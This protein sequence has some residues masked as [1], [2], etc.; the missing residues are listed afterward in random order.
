MGIRKRFL[1]KIR[2][3]RKTHVFAG[4]SELA[5]S[6]TT[7]ALVWLNILVQFLFPM[8]LSFSPVLASTGEQHF[9]IKNKFSSDIPTQ[10]YV[11]TEGENV[12]SVTRKFNISREALR[13]LNQFRVFS[14]GFDNITAGDELDVPV[15]A[16]TDEQQ[17]MAATRNETDSASRKLAGYASQAGSFFANGPDGDSAAAM[18]RGMATS[19]ATEEIQNWLNRFG[20]ARVRLSANEDFS[21]DDSELDL[22]IPL[23]DRG[24]NMAFTQGSV[25]R[26]D[27]RTQANLGFGMRH[28]AD[29]YMFG[30]NVFGDYDIS[31]QHARLGAGLEYWRDYLKVGVNGYK[32]LTG[33]KD[34]PDLDDYEERPADGWDVR[35]QGWL[36]AYPQLGGKLVYEQYY[37]DEVGLFG[38][39]DLQ[40][41]PHAV[42]AGVTYTPFPL[43]T[44]S[45][46][47]RQGQSGEKDTQVALD[48]NYQ[49][50]VPWRKQLDSG[51]VADMRTLSGSRYDLVERNNNIVLQYRKK[52]LI[53][54][55]TAKLVTGHAGEKKSLGVSVTSKYGVER[56]DWSAPELLAAGGVIGKK[57]N[58]WGV[59]LPAWKSGKNA[60]NTYSV[61]GIAVDTKGNRS[62]KS[63][64]QVTVFK[65]ALSAKNST[66][67]PQKSTLPADGKSKQTLTLLVRDDANKAVDI[68]TSEITL[69]TSPVK[70]AHLSELAEKGTGTYELTVTAGKDAEVINVTPKIAGVSLPTATIVINSL[71]PDAHHSSFTASPDH[72]P[73]DNTT[74]SVLTFRAGD[75]QGKQITGI[76]D[77][78][79]FVAGD[80]KTRKKASAE[81]LSV[82]E[83]TESDAGIYTATVKGSKAMNTTF[84]P[85]FDNARVGELKAPLTLTATA[86]AELQSAISVDKPTYAAGDTIQVTVSLK[87]ASGNPVAG[88]AGEL[89]DSTV[90]VPN[91]ALTGK[92]TD[93]NNGT[94]SAAYKAETAGSNLK[95]T[96]KL[97]AWSKAVES[98]AYDITATAPDQAQSAITVDKP[99]YKAGDAISVTVTLKDKAGNI[100]AGA[101]HALTDTTVHVQ[102][103]RPAGQWTDNGDGTYAAAYTALTAGTGLK[104]TLQ[105]EGWS[106]ADESDAYVITAGDAVA[107]QSAIAV[108]KPAYAAGDT[109]AVTVTLK[110]T[111]SNGVTGK[112]DV[113]TDSTVK[114]PNASLTGQW[115]D[116]KNGTYSAAYK[117][118]TAGSNLK[119]T[120]KLSGWN[121]TVESDAYGITATAPDQAKS[122][123]TVDKPAYKAGDAI[124]VTVTLKDKAGNIVAGAAD[125]LTDTTVHVQNAR[126]AGQWTDNGDG[127]YAS[128]Y[129]ALTAGTGLK[130]TL[131]LEGWSQADESDAYVITAGDAVAKQSAIA[132]DKPAYA[133]GETI[134]VTVTLKDT[135]SNG[136]TGKA[137]ALTDSTVKVPNASQAGQWTD[138]GDGTYSAAYTAKTVGTDLKATLQ[139]EGWSQADESD[140]YGI[141]ATAPDQAQSAITVDKS[142]YK[143]GDA[144]SVTVTLKDKAG[145]VVTGAA[146]ALTDTTVKVQ[147]ARPAGQWTDNG[148]GTY[149]AAYTALTAGTGL[150]AT[151]Q[152]E[153]WSKADESAV[154]D[155]V[156]GDAVAGQSAIAVDKPAYAAGDTIAVTVTL[157][158]TGSNAVTGKADALTDSTVKVPNASLTGQ[159]TDNGDGTYSAAYTANTVGTDLK[160]TL[161]LEGWSQAD[162]SDAYVITAGDAVAEQSAIAVDK[163]AYTAGEAISVTV[164]LKD[165]AGNIVAG[166]ADALSDTTVKVQN[167]TLTGKWTDNGDGTYSA[168]YTAK[169][170]GTDLKATLQLEGWS[171]ADE[172]DAY[173]ITAGDAVAEQSA[174]AVDKPAYAAGDTIA[175]TV[176]L[177]DTG[178]NAVTGKADALTDSTVKVPNASQAGQWTDNGDGTYS[179][180]Y[181]AKTV[182]TDLKAT[183]QLEGW[184]KADE[185]DAYGI[186]ATAPDQ[187][188]SSIAVDKPAYK[189]GDAISVTV[190]LKDKAGNVVTGAADALTDA[191]VKVQNA[192]PAGQWTDNGDGTY[193]ATYTARTAGTGLK[194]TLQLEDW[195]QADESDAYDIVA[196]DAVAGE[197]AIAVDKPAYAAG[198][199]I[200]VTVTLKDTGS[201]AVTGKADALTDSTVK[202]PNAGL[203]GQWTDNGDGTYSAAYTANTVGTD[204]KATLQLEGWSQADESDV[205]T[206]T[207][208]EAAA[209]QSTITVAKSSY[210]AGQDVKVIV[211]LK[212]ESGNAVSGAVDSLNDN[213][214]TVPGTSGLTGDWTESREGQYE[215]T[216]QAHTVGTGLTATL[217]L[218]DWSDTVESKSSYEIIADRPDFDNSE[219]TVDKDTYEVGEEIHAKAIIKDHYGNKAELDGITSTSCSSCDSDI[220]GSDAGNWI[221]WTKASDGAYTATVKAA[222]PG[223]DYEAVIYSADTYISPESAELHSNKYAV[224]AGSP[225]AEQSAIKVDK[226]SYTSGETIK[227]TVSLKDASGNAVVGQTDALT[228]DTVKVSGAATFT[229][230]WSDSGDGTY[231]AE[232]TA[233]TAGTGLKATLQL[234]GW[235]KANESGVYDITAGDAV[236]EASA[237]KV[238]KKAYKTGETIDVTVTL[239]DAGNNAVAGAAQ[240]LTDKSVK[241]EGAAAFTGTWT[242]NGDG[243]YSAAYTAQ[244]PGTD[245]KATL[246]LEGW[247]KAD[248]SDVYAITAGAAAAAQ[249]TI[250]VAES[251]Y[252]AG[253]DVK[254]IVHLKDESGNAVSGAVDSLNDNTVTVPGTSGLT[255][256]WTESGNGTYEAT[257]QAH[258]VGTNLTATL[259]LK[260]WSDTVESE[261]S[262]EIIADRPD[263][264]NSELTVDKDTYEVGEE[265]HAKAIFKDHY[266]NMAELALANTG[267]D[268]CSSKIP[269][270]D[271]TGWI[272]WT[273]ASDGVYTVTVKA[274]QPGTDYEAVIYSTGGTYASDE[275]AELHSNKYAVTAGSPVAEQS[276]IKV[277]KSSYT[278]GDDIKV[279]IT[280][281]NEKGTGVTGQM[282]NLQ[283]RVTVPGSKADNGVWVE[284]A[285][286]VYTRTYVAETTGTGLKASV[287]YDGWAE[288]VQSEEYA[289]RTVPVADNS[290]IAVDKSSY[291][292]GDVITATLT[293]RDANNLP[294]AGQIEDVQQWSGNNQN[295]KVANAELTGEWTE[296]GNGVYTGTYTA[297]E[298]GTALKATLKAP[299]WGTTKS[300]GIYEITAGAPDR[301]KSTITAGKSHFTAGEYIQPVVSLKDKY[302]N[303]VT[304]MSKELT[305]STVTIPG[306]SG[307]VSPS[308]K[309]NGDGTYQSLNSYVAVTATSGD[310]YPELQLEGWTSPVKGTGYDI[311]AAEASAKHTVVKMNSDTYYTG[312]ASDGQ[313]TMEVTI[314]FKDNFDN[315]T[316]V[317]ASTVPVTIP[318]S[319]GGT[320]NAKKV[321]DSYRVTAVTKTVGKGYK[322]T[323]TLSGWTEAVESEPYDVLNIGIKELAVNGYTVKADAGFPTTGFNGA[324]FTIVMDEGSRVSDYQWS[325][326]QSWVSVDSKGVVT[327]KGTGNGNSVN[328]YGQANNGMPTITYTFKLNSWY[329]NN[330]YTDEAHWLNWSDTNDFCT[331]SGA[332]IPTIMQLT[333]DAN[334]K[335]G[336]GA[337]GSLLGEWGH[338][339]SYPGS[340]FAWGYYWSADQKADGSHIYIDF[341]TGG[342]YTDN[343]D[344]YKHRPVCRIGL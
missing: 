33:W 102:N 339:D 171:Q 88:Y 48:V 109:I 68:D 305:A 57:G 95:A 265:I 293:L 297:E 135:G 209:A 261:S 180:A 22:L 228:E 60:V 131:Q 113:L 47:H 254:V 284:S 267:C 344:D 270:S 319:V 285:G 236:V 149:A 329:I 288:A 232:Y 191:T 30:T 197:S 335:F 19:A 223:T 35:L 314:T 185:S 323:T 301:S 251:R 82:S 92:W 45:L 111:G 337:V 121:K 178:S 134:A 234:S 186:T 9:I 55:R 157:K 41:N 50:G 89:T 315:V 72:I 53:R 217:K 104:A 11:L 250:T 220:P 139:L 138:N 3:S 260:D 115:T 24:N 159:W 44:V 279:T 94:Y 271:E 249:S 133:A 174:I 184:S 278:S 262:Y 187:A 235:S 100:V 122:A 296:K 192:R 23:Y 168:A 231:T 308:F 43:M 280:L 273:K 144:I 66:F 266:G 140:A 103:A 137:D 77:R 342:K 163:P 17:Q 210:T 207:A 54:L 321:S 141:T 10:V 129:T 90:T 78:L 222:Q 123:I 71:I 177:K 64:S 85:L 84:V 190:S 83:I 13:R 233:K 46:D 161:Q 318:G 213:T 290:T 300:S 310:Y 334:G 287:K 116:N 151:L 246:Q 245:L 241:V 253:Q 124:S 313:K 275:T 114:V 108:D 154:Y 70:S 182:G 202:V 199:T 181:T 325:S 215:A 229:G 29:D 153:D 75:A 256:D 158:D 74:T 76:A 224:T 25:H 165:K 80:A 6:K 289:I 148:D 79:S 306:A 146:D 59:K 42:T 4:S 38:A 101:A 147:N 298:A 16:L 225:V 330:G 206:I 56:I 175:V 112:A 12:D 7:R 299:G 69:T 31:R 118:Q 49:L 317:D 26:T 39:D 110:D 156:A 295:I 126:P 230:T 81:A 5:N 98:D 166:A 169:T 212:D 244:T 218:K 248:E 322:A 170:A 247:S 97:S 326:N 117:A 125:A 264:D 311:T 36:P 173:V 196:G 189:A 1:L 152:L 87:D 276:A 268:N 316:T 205:Y 164:T 120:L 333:A 61:A 136:V 73:A 32:R 238:D 294:V 221:Q 269:G 281:L 8:A 226:T 255:G 331:Q 291:V 15:K 259:K 160:A 132:V 2:E 91:A 257:Y 194:A 93:N 176:T 58:I 21:L 127:T 145:N 14:R 198:E 258:T 243:T 252:T 327:F 52:E 150:K 203:S 242:D 312:A 193:A 332:V 216:Y 303:V 200:A 320:Y 307:S 86:P 282:N 277:D 143:A 40:K 183:L 105:L 201:N 208:A 106:Q 20:T 172:S 155:I 302:G 67:T 214:V 204:L 179:A 28:F 237:I 336:Q 324:K 99:A 328:I 219:L 286:G 37:G 188:Q 119:A 292:A 227:V 65:P 240:G 340:N 167:A 211:Q 51:A 62:E 34:S 304:G 341:G 162:E 309:D 130:A 18:A 274:A 128:T 338:M 343:T 107:E 195:S 239:I 96:L 272:Q 142:A 27:D 263:F 283:S 63:V